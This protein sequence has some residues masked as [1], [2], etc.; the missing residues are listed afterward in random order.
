M[1]NIEPRNENGQAHGYC[2]WY[3]NNGSVAYKGFY[4]H[5][6]PVG[7]EEWYLLDNNE[8]SYKIYHI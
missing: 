6:K 5:G 7:Y 3:N 1:K 8:L 4:N 2:E